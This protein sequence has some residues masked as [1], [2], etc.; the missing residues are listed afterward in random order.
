MV[1]EEPLPDTLKRISGVLS[2]GNRF[3]MMTHEDPDV[4]G[5]GSMLALGKSLTDL[6][7]EVVILILKPLN[8]PLALLTGAEEMFTVLKPG[9][10]SEAE[11]EFDAVLALDCAERERL[12]ACV[13][14]WSGGSLTINLDH[15][16]TNTFF[17]QHNLVDVNSSSTGELVYRLI[18]TGG[19]P[20]D[21]EI[22]ENLFAAI[23]SDT[24]S[25]RY[26]NTTSNAMRISAD[27]M[28]YGVNPWEIS[29]K[30]L[31]GYGPARLKLLAGALA[32]VE[33]HNEG[34]IGMMTL[35]REM[36]EESGA[37]GSDCEGFVDYPRHVDGVELA[38]MIRE[39][40]VNTYKFSIR[41]NAWV[42]VAELASHFGGGGHAKAAGFT[43]NGSLGTLKKDFL[44]EAGRLLNETPR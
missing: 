26:S 31:N 30:I 32:R 1:S 8:P 44:L 38:V 33:F 43:G 9:G 41:S 5:L 15:H 39:R 10:V 3:L 17:G 24:G 11:R 20:L 42:N 6:G 19:F 27:L 28:E 16:E 18:R 13:S 25:F 37:L 12:G 34:R 36:F 22:A 7:K 14:A 35:S 23:Q 21:F 2:E 29:Q 4:D 40:D